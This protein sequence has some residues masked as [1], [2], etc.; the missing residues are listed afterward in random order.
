MHTPKF[1]E[2]FINSIRFFFF[3]KLFYH[4]CTIKFPMGRIIKFHEATIYS[5]FEKWLFSMNEEMESI[6]KNQTW[7]LVKLL[8]G[9]WAVRLKWIF[10]RKEGIPRIKDERF[11]AHLVAK[12]FSHKEG[13]NFN[14]M[15]SPFMCC[16][17]YWPFII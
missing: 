16:L 17:H 10:K 9:K 1:I 2:V 15:F 6:H 3:A 12:G 13:I 8:E 11:K 4:F 14:E 7:D 5:K